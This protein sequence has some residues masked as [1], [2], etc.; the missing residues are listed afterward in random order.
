MDYEAARRNMVDSQIR[1]NKVTHPGLLAAL[2]SVPRE[3]F[4]PADRAFAA[5]LD[6]DIPLAPGRFLMEPMVFARLV[7]LAEPKP[8]DRA[9]VIGSGLGYGAAVLAHLVASIVAL[10]SDVGLAAR[11]KD[12]LAQL[13]IHNV[14]QVTGPLAQGWAGS[15]PYDLILIEG[16][17]EEIP[18]AL[19]GQMADGGRLV[20][21]VATG[22]VG[23]ATLFMERQKVISHRP[24]FDAAVPAL[25]EFRRQQGF[26]F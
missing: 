1:T 19:F 5:Y 25:A 17:V 21:V 15:A 10:E 8:E 3:R 14:V 22:G 2:S 26:V 4:L 7:Q 11:G 23:R 12:Q 20:A 18:Q 24:Y 13:A 16:S 9:L 6:D